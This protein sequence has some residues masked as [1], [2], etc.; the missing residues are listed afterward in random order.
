M[1]P[2]KVAIIIRDANNQWEGLRSTIGLS[3]EMIEADIF[4]LGEVDMPE[5]RVEGYKDNLEFLDDMEGRAFTDCRA[6]LEKW[7]FFEH[8]PVK[9][10]AELLTLYDLV[11]PF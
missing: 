10:I 9:E 4:V 6:N 3:I 7:G 8:R 11:I 2:K 1:E 5:E